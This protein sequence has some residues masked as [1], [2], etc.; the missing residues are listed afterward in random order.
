MESKFSLE[1]RGSNV[2]RA[3]KTSGAEEGCREEETSVGTC[4]VGG[5]GG[6]YQGQQWKWEWKRSKDA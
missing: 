1:A 2:R 5:A 3:A 6:D 4:R